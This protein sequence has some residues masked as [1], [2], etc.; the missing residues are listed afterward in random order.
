MLPRKK[1]INPRE[2][3]NPEIHSNRR[4]KQLGIIVPTKGRRA[5]RFALTGKELDKLDPKDYPAPYRYAPNTNPHH[6]EFF[7]RRRRTTKKQEKK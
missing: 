7:D 4:K 5:P 1:P 6:F 2:K 3:F